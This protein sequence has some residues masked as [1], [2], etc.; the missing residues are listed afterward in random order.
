V[1]TKEIIDACPNLQYIGEMATG[2]NNIDV[3]YAAQKGI[4]CTNVPAYSTASV[5]QH[6]IALLLE[7]TNHVQKHA[8]SIAAGEWETKPQF[9]Y[10]LSPIVELDGKT[11]GLV[12]FGNTGIR[13]AQIANALGMKV[14]VYT[15]TKKPEYENDNLKFVTLDELLAQSDVISLHCPLNTQTDKMINAAAIQ[16][17]KDGALL[18]N[19]ARGGLL[20]EQAVADALNSGKLGGAALDV[21]SIEPPV[22]NPLVGA[23]NCILTPHIAW[24]SI[25][26]RSRL[27]DVVVQNAKAFMDGAPK[28]VVK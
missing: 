26:A 22:N 8:S 9:C 11:L 13:T 10:W 3:A 18:L 4:V 17:M 21:L 5:A 28:N 19:T 25:E 1:I 12:G 2:Y 24:A 20:D 16:K 23:K 7:L 6:T 27:M 14:L 15:R